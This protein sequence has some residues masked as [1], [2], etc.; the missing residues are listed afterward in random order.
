MFPI[1]SDVAHKPQGTTT[2][3]HHAR[4]PLSGIERSAELR[5]RRL[6]DPER[7]RSWKTISK[8][9]HGTRTPRSPAS[10]IAFS[11][12]PSDRIPITS[13]STVGSAEAARLRT[14]IAI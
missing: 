2:C 5:E 7:L 8:K 9:V 11:T 10:A 3:A 12:V 13:S 4:R 6:F 1:S 14:P